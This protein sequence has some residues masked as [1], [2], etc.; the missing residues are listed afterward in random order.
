MATIANYFIVNPLNLD[1]ENV[2]HSIELEIRDCQCNRITVTLL[3]DTDQIDDMQL[4]DAFPDHSIRA[5]G[6]IKPFTF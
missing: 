3:L 1:H 5:Y 6:Y 2:T 4:D